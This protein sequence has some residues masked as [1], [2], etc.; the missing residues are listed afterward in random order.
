M[1]RDRRPKPLPLAPR[2]WLLKA[3]GVPCWFAR[4]RRARRSCGSLFAWD[5]EACGRRGASDRAT[6]AGRRGRPAHRLSSKYCRNALRDPHALL[7][8]WC[9]RDRE[10]GRLSGV[11][12]DYH[13][14]C[15]LIR[16]LAYRGHIWYGNN[17]I[18]VT[19][20]VRTNDVPGSA[21]GH[22]STDGVLRRRA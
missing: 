14:I 17:A 9:S 13:S 16:I 7:H 5:R 6:R 1:A 2:V 3:I 11:T 8:A 22:F 19:V 21:N 18:T 10:P 4:A 12:V 15:N 20:S